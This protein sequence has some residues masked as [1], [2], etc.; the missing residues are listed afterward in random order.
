M[1]IANIIIFHQNPAYV[2]RLLKAM[3]HPDVD[4]YLH[5]D[6]KVDMKPFLHLGKLSNTYFIRNR[7]NATWAGYSQ[8]EAIVNSL[9]EIIESKIPYDFVNLLSGQDY[10]IKPITYILKVLS[11]NIG[12]S[13]MISETPPSDWWNVAETRFTKYHF[14]DYG[15]RGKYRLADLV[16]QIL[17]DRK[18]P[19]PYQL[20]GGPYAAYWILSMDAAVYIH[21][22]LN[23]K[24]KIYWFFKHTWA[25][26]EFII[27]TILMNSPFRETIVNENYHY[28]SWE[29]G[30]VRPSILTLKDFRKLQQSDKFFA[31]KFDPA[32]DEKILDLIDEQL[33]KSTC[34]Y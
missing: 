34:G 22:I 27:N 33:L 25:P 14:S 12:K 26:D 32:I 23:K 6:K 10:P 3:T 1:R 20:F 11:E 17:P 9:E 15:F 2:D 24:D 30:E 13:F 4:F 18:F 29:P 28:F 8:V 21:S 5:L 16:S 7:K 31:R 19:L